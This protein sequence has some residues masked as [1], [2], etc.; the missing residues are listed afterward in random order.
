MGDS[1]N[2][3][4]LKLV[5]IEITGFRGIGPKLKFRFDR[6][7]VLIL[8]DNRQGKSSVLNAI[9]W[10]FYGEEVR[11]VA[12]LNFP[13]RK[14]WEIANRSVGQS[15]IVLKLKDDGGLIHTL[16]RYHQRRREGI[17]LDG[18]EIS[19]DKLQAFLGGASIRDFATLNYLH[20]ESLEA[21]LIMKP[22]DRREAILRLLGVPDLV[23]YRN[24]IKDVLRSIR[25]RPESIPLNKIEA[26]FEER[27]RSFEQ[28][29]IDAE[30]EL[31]AAGLRDL[32]VEGATLL[33]NEIHERL[34]K[35]A[36]DYKVKP[37]KLP[38]ARSVPKMGQFA[39]L[40]RQEARRL[41]SERP[42][43]RQYRG[44][45]ARH[46]RG[47]GLHAELVEA[48]KYYNKANNELR[49]H[50]D[51]FGTDKNL[52]KHLNDLK[53]NS[54]S[55]KKELAELNNR[56]EVIQAAAEYLKQVPTARECPVCETLKPDLREKLSSWLGKYIPED[57]RKLVEELGVELE[58]LDTESSLRES[59]IKN[60]KEKE[61][62]LNK[63]REEVRVF[64][65]LRSLPAAM[66]IGVLLRDKLDELDGKLKGFESA[67][68]GANK[69]IG[70]IEERIKL[71]EKLLGLIE[72]RQHIS[73][74]RKFRE[75]PKWRKAQSAINKARIH[76]EDLKQLERAL[77]DTERD[78][79]SKR[80]ESADKHIQKPYQKIVGRK[81]YDKLRLD[82]EKEV[83]VY[84]ESSSDGQW[85]D[86]LDLNQGDVVG[87]AVSIFLGLAGATNNRLNFLLLDDPSQKMDPRHIRGMVKY[88]ND[89][90]TRYQLTIATADPTL[91]S[92]LRK[93]YKFKK[94][95]YRLFGHDERSGPKKTEA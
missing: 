85:Q 84:V 63:K 10:V 77:G 49:K 83:E 92:E 17:R 81:L 18:R 39:N 57:L 33:V 72:L 1:L 75:H 6:P 61:K 90:G 7:C 82:Y 2:A 28:Q 74:L 54:D 38:K 78:E 44:L 42:Q 56:A 52:E 35:F 5:G 21:V 11:K 19:Q 24:Q 69:T 13:E 26:K 55:K 76:V 91:E 16:E 62:A 46:T 64:L 79:V 9:E 67:V 50:R 60:V 3:E 37:A 8:G 36:K 34:R 95:I 27:S 47:S 87:I 45:T 31:Q 12:A 20:Q 68:K 59:L 30:K 23:N 53:I 4:K 22:T 43:V 25:D 48:Q 93:R 66:D 29:A 40:A 32:K 58:K 73:N 65:K 70:E 86:A 94:R 71:L 15:N 88:L 80:I 14:N 51:D 41:L 89:M